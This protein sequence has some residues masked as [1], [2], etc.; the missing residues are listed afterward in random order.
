MSANFATLRPNHEDILLKGNVSVECGERI[1][2]TGRLI[3][4][5]E[6]GTIQTDDYFVFRTPQRVLQ[7]KQLSTDFLLANPQYSEQPFLRKVVFQPNR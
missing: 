4:A 6:N 1:L 3:V 7:G 5:L 2:K